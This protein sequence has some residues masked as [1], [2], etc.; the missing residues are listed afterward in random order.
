[1]LFFLPD[2][3]YDV[4][5]RGQLLPSKEWIVSKTEDGVLSATVVDH[6]TGIPESYAITQFDRE[7]A[8]QFRLNPDI[9][10]SRFVSIGDT[11]GTLLSN[12]TN[13]ELVRLRALLA[14]EKATL[15]VFTSGEK[16]AAVES[17]RREV[18]RA[19]AQVAE[20]EKVVARVRELNERNVASE[21][22][23]EREEGQLRLFTL[24]VEVAQA[25]LNEVRTGA[26]PAE[27]A[28]VE[29]RIRGLEEEIRA[30]EERSSQFT[31][32]SPLAG[33]LYPRTSSDTLLVVADTRAYVM[34][35]P[36][37]WEQRPFLEAGQEVVLESAGLETTHTGRL[38]RMD[39]FVSNFGGRQGFMAMAEF[40]TDADLVPGIH[41]RCTIRTSEISPFE[42]IRRFF[43]SSLPAA[44]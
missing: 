15:N 26:K 18:V 23:L 9:A 21:Q 13:R 16:S 25:R 41:A 29:A 35:M 37:A 36:V 32:E 2:T 24:D 5:T 4:T 30:F 3:S 6:A 19:E 22:E 34:F 40:A 43:R 20:Q 12:Q 11:V 39:K 1:M 31:L 17:A 8:L 7:D 10:Q 42:H 33:T 14:T 38:I 28:L 44:Q 27:V